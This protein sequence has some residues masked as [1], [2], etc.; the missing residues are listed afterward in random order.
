MSNFQEQLKEKRQEQTEETIF[1]LRNQFTS[2][3]E[4][5]K[6]LSQ[7]IA[8]ST[9]TTKVLRNWYTYYDQVFEKMQKTR[10]LISLLQSLRP[11]T[12]EAMAHTIDDQLVLEISKLEKLEKQEH[13]WISQSI[14]SL[15]SL[16]KITPQLPRLISVAE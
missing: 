15:T 9:V 14:T 10:E 2:F 8:E 12:N 5:Y 4:A 6:L 13:Q 11:N 16:D 3:A 1:L 7:Y